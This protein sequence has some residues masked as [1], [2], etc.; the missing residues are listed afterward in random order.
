MALWISGN[1]VVCRY[2]ELLDA[3]KEEK[4]KKREEERAAKK[5]KEEAEKKPQEEAVAASKEAADDLD[6][7][8][9]QGAEPM[10]VDPPAGDSTP[11][12][13]STAI[14]ASTPPK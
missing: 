6:S 1:S 7:G 4:R 10:E 13:A 14:K 9:P 8:A 3:E 11:T 5:A 12:E 2:Q